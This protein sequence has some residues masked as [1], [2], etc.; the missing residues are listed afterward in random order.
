MIKDDT[1]PYESI[2]HL[3]CAM[4]SVGRDNNNI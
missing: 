4:Q 2:L 3:D 1:N